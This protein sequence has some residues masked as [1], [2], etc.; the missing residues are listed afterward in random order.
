MIRPG[1]VD[2]FMSWPYFDGWAKKPYGPPPDD[3]RPL[4]V[5]AKSWLLRE[6]WKRWGVI[7]LN[8]RPRVKPK[9]VHA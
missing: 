7:G 5:P 1:R 2:A 6:G 9:G 4:V 3:E 8:E